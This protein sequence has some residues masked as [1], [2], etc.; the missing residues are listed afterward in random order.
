MKRREKGRVVSEELPFLARRIRRQN[1]LAAI[2]CGLVFPSFPWD[3]IP[4]DAL[5]IDVL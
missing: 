5:Y 1:K 4:I 3:R 2:R